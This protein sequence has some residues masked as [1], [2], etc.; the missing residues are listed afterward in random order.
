MENLPKTY[1]EALKDGYTQN[2]LKYQRGYVSRK[3]D[4]RKQPV[5]I[6][7]GSRKGQLYILLPNF[8]STQYCFRAYLKKKVEN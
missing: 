6:A 2:D 4:I 8:D 1:E 3:V 5:L 7:G